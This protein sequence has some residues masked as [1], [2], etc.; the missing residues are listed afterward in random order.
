[1]SFS[2]RDYTRGSGG[3]G[4]FFGRIFGS[5]ENPMTW[6]LP[7]YRAWGIAVR[8]HIFF[9]VFI[10][11][12]VVRSISHEH[13]G[14]GETLVLMGTLFGIVLLH[15]YGHCI[16]CRRV[17]GEADEILLWPLGGLASC[18]PPN[19]W[20]AHFWTTAGGPLVNVALFPVFA[21]AVLLMTG[22]SLGAVWFNPFDPGTG[23]SAAVYDIDS[24]VVVAAVVLA[25]ACYF[26]NWVLLAFNVL[27]PVYPL[28]GGR[29]LHAILW[30]Q[31]G[32]DRAT[33]IAAK[34]GLGGAITLGIA[35]LVFSVFTF[36]GVA[37]F[38]G[39]TSWLELQRLKMG[40]TGEDP[41]IAASKAAAEGESRSDRRAREAAA[42]KREKKEAEAKAEAAEVDRILEKISEHGIHSLTGKERK[43]LDRQ[44][45][46]T[47]QS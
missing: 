35:G 3:G 13:I 34:I 44:G 24:P 16:A 5:G 19:T 12:E 32:R 37:I 39:F 46:T 43:F 9:V 8:I 6:A 25:W 11:L 47:G 4:G 38:A 26:T 10:V 2:D 18:S 31:M 7:L 22:G 36:V 45:K 20:T 41:I 15:E 27:L 23:L 29:L 1:M 28:D 17:G 30:R 14:A 21:A 42:K 40:M 33:S